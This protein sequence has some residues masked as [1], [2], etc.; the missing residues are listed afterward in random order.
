V[1]FTRRPFV[2][3]T[4]RRARHPNGE[5]GIREVL[6]QCVPYCGFPAAID[7]LRTAREV[8]AAWREEQGGS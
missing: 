3:A 7:G 8:L 4:G 6:L 5:A 2:K 1:T